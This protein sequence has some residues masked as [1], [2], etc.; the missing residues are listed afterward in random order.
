M[1]LPTT[2]APG[3]KNT[4]G[5]SRLRP[6]GGAWAKDETG[7]ANSERRL[8]STPPARKSFRDGHHADSSKSLTMRVWNFRKTMTETRWYHSRFA[9]GLR[10]VLHG[11]VWALLMVVAIFFALFLP[12]ISTLAGNKQ[13]TPIDIVLT[14]IMVVFAIEMCCLTVVDANYIFSF[15]PANG[16]R[17]HNINDF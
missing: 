7:S 5:D 9:D 12:E 17:R 16:H 15:F 11:R 2:P 3:G 10:S 13:D 8:S 6:P 4:A 14:L 1:V